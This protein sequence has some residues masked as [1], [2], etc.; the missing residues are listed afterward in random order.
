[1][2]KLISNVLHGTTNDSIQSN[3]HH[4][5]I[6]SL[7]FRF[8]L[9]RYNRACIHMDLS[10]LVEIFHSHWMLEYATQLGNANSS[11]LSY[12]CEKCGRFAVARQICSTPECQSR[13]L[14]TLEWYQRPLLTLDSLPPLR[15]IGQCRGTQQRQKRIIRS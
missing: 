1:M 11:A 6:F 9:N 13:A 5:T 3:A 7:I 12:V 4:I 14:L 10:I 8:H 2:E 15:S